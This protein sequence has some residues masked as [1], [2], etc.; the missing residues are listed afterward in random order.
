[1]AKVPVSNKDYVSAL[2]TKYDFTMKML[3]NDSK[4]TTEILIQFPECTLLDALNTQKSD[5]SKVFDLPKN[6]DVTLNEYDGNVAVLEGGFFQLDDII[7]TNAY[8]DIK[9]NDDLELISYTSNINYRIKVS[10]YTVLEKLWP[11]FFEYLESYG[12][13]VGSLADF[14]IV[15]IIMK[16]ISMFTDFD[17][18]AAMSSVYTDYNIMY[19]MYELDWTP[20][21]FGDVDKN[22]LVTADDARTLLRTSVGLASIKNEG[23]RFFA[24]MNFDGAITAGDARLALRVSVGLE[25]KYTTYE[26][27][28]AQLEGNWENPD[29]PQIPDTPVEVPDEPE[30][31]EIPLD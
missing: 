28:Q 3:R 15:S 22:N 5:L 1:M 21:Y 11:T 24:D 30:V 4:Q 25:K 8:V 26:M 16:I 12:I 7:C 20:R 6:T 19:Q 27:R 13:E 2:T 31:P 10:T 18:E 29:E 9:Y 23:D 14:N 17:P